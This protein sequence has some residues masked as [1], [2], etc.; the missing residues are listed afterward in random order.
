M[1]VKNTLLASIEVGVCF[2]KEDHPWLQSKRTR[3]GGP[4]RFAPGNL[5][6]E[7]VYE[8]LHGEEID[9]IPQEF[10]SGLAMKVPQREHDIVAKR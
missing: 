2:V 9:Y 10:I 6:R 8:P 1:R 3:K 7:S 4:L 5:V